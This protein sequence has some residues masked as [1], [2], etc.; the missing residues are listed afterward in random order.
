[1]ALCR[2]SIYLHRGEL[3]E[4]AGAFTKTHVQRFR[5]STGDNGRSVRP[6]AL[7][8]VSDAVAAEDA[9][10]IASKNGSGWTEVG[11]PLK[12]MQN[13]DGSD[14]GDAGSALQSRTCQSSTDGVEGR[15]ST[16]LDSSAG[17]RSSSD[18]DSG[19]ECEFV[20]AVEFQAEHGSNPGEGGGENDGWR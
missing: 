3:I 20:D 19:N 6:D 10:G 14:D 5:F 1:M 17:C 7:L 12:H 15:D 16:L 8:I 4:R 9:H 13:C 11:S 2:S 18:G